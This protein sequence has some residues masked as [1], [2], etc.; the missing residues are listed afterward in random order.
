MGL[1]IKPPSWGKCSDN[2]SGTPDVA[3]LGTAVTTGA[4]NALGTSVSLI[5]A[6]THDV[7]YIVIMAGGFQDTGD[8][9]SALLNILVDPAGGESWGSSPLIPD[10]LVGKTTES[11]T[12]SA[13]PCVTYHFPLFVPAG[14]S[15][16][17]N[18]QNASALNVVGQVV[19]FAY[20]ANANPGSWWAGQRVTAIGVDQGSSQ[21]TSHTPGDASFSSWANFGSTLSA[22]CGAIQ[23]AAGGRISSGTD[24]SVSFFYEFG[25]DS[26]R[27]GGTIVRATTT[28]ESGWQTQPG[29]HFCSLPSGTQLQVR[30][31]ASA[32]PA[33]MQVAAYAVH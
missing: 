25:V 20:G 22:Q 17:A 23:F 33:S 31:I 5:A 30:A 6:L 21:G 1:I 26:T 32:T 15:L 9:T 4:S 2:L 27:L 19:I 28:A 24:G 11:T 7:E 13:F 8:N 16:G 14:T 10:L 3:A 12:T 29:V 18:A